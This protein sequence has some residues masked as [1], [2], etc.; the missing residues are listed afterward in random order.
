MRVAVVLYG[1]LP[2]AGGGFTFQ[3]T[4]VEALRRL[5]SETQH[6]FVYYT[7]GAS[8]DSLP[9]VRL[10]SGAPRRA[11]RRV[12]EM[13]RDFQ[14]RFLGIRGFDPRTWFERSLE[15]NRIEFVWF[16][17]NYVEDCDQPFIFTVW[18]LEHLSQP[19]FPEVSRRGEWERRQRHFSRY[20]P[21]ATRIIVPSVVGRDQLVRYFSVGPERALVLHHPV[22][23]FAL[24]PASTAD[25]GMLQRN[26]IN[27]PYVF[28]PAQ[29]WAHKNH[30]TLFRMLSVLN[31]DSTNFQLV[32]AGS[33]KG[34]LEYIKSIALELGVADDVRFL[35][36][37]SEDDLVVLYRHAH[38]LAYPSFFG[39]ENMPPVEALALGCPVIAADVPGAREQ[40]GKAA[41]LVPP[42]DAG[43]FADAVK[44]LED[45]SL[46]QQLVEAGGEQVGRYS[47]DTYVKGVVSFLDEF[48]GVRR[49]WQ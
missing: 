28:Y 34:E 49:C 18:D 7:V 48:E 38:A 31:R 35:G 3:Q 32:L 42:T 44:R 13:T 45:L 6:E 19:W 11:T 9:A 4:V 29:F 24:R 46:R 20:L 5:E 40:L 14:D 22:P 26:Q 1:Y 33:D 17:A 37:V 41:L 25:G 39:P 36:F 8:D 16:A 27:K 21:K 23:A 10:P 47:A 30:F 2:E 15:R 12:I 43:R